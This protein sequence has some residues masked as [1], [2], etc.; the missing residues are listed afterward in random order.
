MPRT[1][2][3]RNLL[4][5][6]TI[7][8][9]FPFVAPIFAQSNEEVPSGF[10]LDRYENVWQRNPFTLVTP[11]V[12]KAQP[13]L[14]DKLILLSWLNDGG[15]D[16]VFVQNTETNG[17]QKIT[18]QANTEDLKLI[19]VHPD[20]DPRKA[21]VILARGSERGIVKFRPEVPAAAAQAAASGPPGGAQTPAAAVSG[22]Q[23]LPGANVQIQGNQ[24]ALEAFQQAARAGP[25]QLPQ[26]GIPNQGENSGRPPRASEIRRKRVTP[27][28]RE[29][30]V[31]PQQPYQNPANQPQGH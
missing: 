10:K 28:L 26:G 15:N 12:T 13:T 16:V 25:A 2:K 8:A 3:L 27:P 6:T 20:P 24:N 18:K 22:P 19:E 1:R 31:N 7:L 29:Q 11:A 4:R 9:L 21:E 30:A 5:T 23:P 14:F 17:V